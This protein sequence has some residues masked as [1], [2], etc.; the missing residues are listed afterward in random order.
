M[1]EHEQHTNTGI[2]IHFECPGDAQFKTREHATQIAYDLQKEFGTIWTPILHEG[3]YH[4]AD[5]GFLLKEK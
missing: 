4:V 2:T 3:H 5:T 1:S